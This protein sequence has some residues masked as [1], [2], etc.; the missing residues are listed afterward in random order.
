MCGIFA[1]FGKVTPQMA[2]EALELSKRQ[3]HRGGDESDYHHTENKCVMVHE[4]L[5]IV[6]VEHGTQPLYSY[7]R[8][9]VMVANGEIYNYKE[10]RKTYFP[11]ERFVTNSDCEIIIKLY[12]TYGLEFLRRNI[13]RGM[14]AFVLYDIRNDVFIVARDHI[15]IIPLYMGKDTATGTIRFSSEMK[16][17]KECDKIKSFEPGSMIIGYPGNIFLNEKWYTEEVF[18][19]LGFNDFTQFDHK[20]FRKI[21]TR[22]VRRHLRM[23]EDVGFGVLLSGGLDSSTIAAITAKIMKK[24]GKTIKTFCIGLEGSP[25]IAAAEKVAKYIGSEHYSFKYTIEEGLA[26]IPDVIKQIETFDTT[27][28]RASTPMYLMAK[29]IKEL[30]IKV[31]L[32]GEVA[33]EIWGS[34]AYFK[35]A[36]NDREFFDETV[37]KVK[38]LHSYDL[39][40]CNKSL[41]AYGIEARVPFADPDVISYVMRLDPKWKRWGSEG[42]PELEK[43]YMRETF[44]GYIPD[45]VLWRKKE[46]FSDGVGYSWVDTIQ[47]HAKEQVQ[48]LGDYKY[49]K[50][51]GLLEPETFEEKYNRYV[52]EQVYGTEPCMM[53]VP[54]QKSVACSTSTA[55]K[56]LK[57]SAIADP[58]GRAI[59]EEGFESKILS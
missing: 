56:W 26:A 37:T 23:D 45:D 36:P 53:T 55:L 47:E 31:V 52:F 27:T 9:I 48:K 2:A 4:R 11:H 14:F 20:T 58:S 5:S 13:L 10:L 17:L 18:V 3:E 43:H 42:F 7:H 6:D 28:I 50:L 19:N 30:G 57:G 44:E 51:D 21:M 34:Y 39:L 24:R 1:I 59:N 32:T 35:H 54:F 41:M 12:E 8:N 22:S 15:G 25:D 40:R 29:K 46:Q 33:D 16:C 38:L 49:M